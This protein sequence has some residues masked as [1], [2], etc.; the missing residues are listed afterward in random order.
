MHEW[1]MRLALEL[2]GQAKGRTTPNPLVGA[3]VVKDGEIVGRGYHRKAGTPHAEIHAIREAG[4]KTRGAILYV[5]LEPC[6][7]FGRTPPCS[8][9]VIKAELA[10]V[11]VAMQDPNPLVTGRGI[12]QM[13]EAGIKVHV[14]LLEK[15]A[16]RLNEVFIKYITTRAPFVVLKTAMTLDGKIAT[17]TGHSTWVT[18]S[19]ARETVHRMRDWYD[20]ILVGVNTVVTDNPAL[21]CRLSEGGQDPIRI[22]LD[23]LAKTPPDAKVVVQKSTAPTYLVVTDRAPVERIVALSS[24]K[25]KIVRTAAGAE[26]RIDLV[27]LLQKLGEME[28]TSILVEGGAEVAAS[29]LE[30][31]LIDKVVTFIAPKIIG[32]SGAPG[33]VGGQGR[34]SMDEAV[35]LREISYGIVGEDLYVEGYPIYSD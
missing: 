3:V 21:T 1:Y 25:A 12:K 28:I 32:G 29:F 19:A 13:T 10:E 14:G 31:R 9:A 11:Y 24:G 6:S 20:A 34:D 2:A 7:H 22:I 35:R 33:P 5:T 16:Q 23:S 18:G 30:A 4:E 8:E 26:G 27:G 15:E 17:H